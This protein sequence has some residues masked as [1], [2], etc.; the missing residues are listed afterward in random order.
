MPRFSTN[1]SM[2]FLEYDLL[3]RIAAAKKAGFGAIEI[4][5]PYDTPVPDLLAA[6]EEAGVDITVFNIG[7]GDLISGG[8]GIS[9]VPGREDQ[10]K[11]AVEEAYDY[12]ATLKPFT[13][14]VLCG[15][16]SMEEFTREQCLN[17]LADNLEY[18]ATAFADTGA[19]VLTEAVNN[20]DRPGYLINY[21]ADALDI[22]DR[23]GHPN[24]K[25]EYDLYHM[26]IMEG[27]LVNTLRN[28]LDRIGNIQFADTPGRNEPGT[29]EINYPYIFEAIDEM[30]W[31]GYL[32]AE[33][34]PSG[35]TE[36]TLG[37]MPD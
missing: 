5:F 17:V 2:M 6:K 33:Y 14:N 20:K 34:N 11:A 21:T 8:P 19:T 12:A 16:P 36:D 9:A 4:Q 30:G 23:A 10:F 32:A 18:A 13:M 31:D 1:I 29:G 27:D 28:N 7:V 22:I 24:L 37:W 26:Q 3:D 15:W 35:R 25:I